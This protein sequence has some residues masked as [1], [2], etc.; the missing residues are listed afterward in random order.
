MALRVAE[1]ALSAT[2]EGGISYV[3]YTV[4]CVLKR[5]Y[6]TENSS[7]LGGHAVR[8]THTH[9]KLLCA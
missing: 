3:Y 7:P 2:G 5:A 6:K 1:E 8:L 4:P 9:K